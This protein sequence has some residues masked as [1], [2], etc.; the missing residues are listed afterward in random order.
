ML[1]NRMD[2]CGNKAQYFAC[3]ANVCLSVLLCLTQAILL[4][5]ELC[6]L[7]GSDCK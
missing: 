7:L 5:P 1:C 2:V 4:R 6:V 3:D